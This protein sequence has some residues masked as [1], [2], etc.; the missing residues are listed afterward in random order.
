[1]R[2]FPLG[3]GRQPNHEPD[4]DNTEPRRV[5]VLGKKIGKIFAGEA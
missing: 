2:R 4:S 3:E 5:P 1:M